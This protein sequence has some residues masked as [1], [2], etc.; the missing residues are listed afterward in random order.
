M[1]LMWAMLEQQ[2]LCQYFPHMF[3]QLLLPTAQPTQRDLSVRLSH[4]GAHA[5]L[6]TATS[7]DCLTAV[8]LLCVAAGTCART[9]AYTPPCTR[10]SSARPTHS[11]K[12]YCSPLAAFIC[13]AA[14]GSCLT[15][16]V[17]HTQSKPQSYCAIAQLSG[18]VTPQGSV[19]HVIPPAA[20]LPAKPTPAGVHCMSVI[21]L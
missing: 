21:R 9:C 4:C 7:T 12:H 2:Q 18:V 3:H 17:S 13:C 11:R 16:R 14:I 20:M 10:A 5:L 1:S 8:C 15:A 19:L 6:V